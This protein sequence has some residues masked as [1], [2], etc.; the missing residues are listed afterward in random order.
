LSREFGVTFYDEATRG[1][2]PVLRPL[3]KKTN[4]SY[5]L[6]RKLVKRG[7]LSAKNERR[8]MHE[9]GNPTDP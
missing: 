1:E 2:I 3:A 6:D 8:M 4:I 5:N 7:G 9:T